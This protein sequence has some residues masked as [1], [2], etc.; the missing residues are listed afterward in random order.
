ARSQGLGR[1]LKEYQRAKVAAIGVESIY[2]SYDPLLAPNAHLNL[3][4]IGAVVR[5]YAVDLYAPAESS[6][7]HRGLGSDR[8]V[9]EW[10][11][12]RPAQRPAPPAA[13]IHRLVRDADGAPLLQPLPDPPP[14]WALI[15]IPAEI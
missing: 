9:V 13:G 7:L 3:E 2:W 6:E 14:D 12:S 11:P 15:E 1:R 5:E 4:I 8:L 10:T